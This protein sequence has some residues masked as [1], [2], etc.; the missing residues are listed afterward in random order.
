M[1]SLNVNIHDCE[2]IDRIDLQIMAIQHNELLFKEQKWP[3]PASQVEEIE[4]EERVF[5]CASMPMGVHIV[6]S[7]FATQIRLDTST[8]H[9]REVDRETE[10]NV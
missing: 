3:E 1:S 6:R 2:R 4:A 7:S 8:V 5:L 9:I 10:E